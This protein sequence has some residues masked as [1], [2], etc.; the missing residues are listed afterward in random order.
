MGY[1]MM[2]IDLRDFYKISAFYFAMEALVLYALMQPIGLVMLVTIATALVASYLFFGA[3]IDEAVRSLLY[4]YLR[5]F[6]LVIWIGLLIFGPLYVGEFFKNIFLLIVVIA[7]IIIS[8]PLTIKLSSLARSK[9]G[10]NMGVTPLTGKWGAVWSLV[11]SIY[12]VSWFMIFYL[13]VVKPDLTALAVVILTI[14]LIAST[15]LGYR[16]LEGSVM[17]AE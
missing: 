11:G 12:I 17:D 7:G 6:R 16:L 14:C 4:P 5:Y 1:I 15:F 2:R 8:G 9:K 3:Q 10:N 13:E